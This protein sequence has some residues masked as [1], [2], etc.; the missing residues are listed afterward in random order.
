MFQ[1]FVS[2]CVFSNFWC[3]LSV[4][5]AFTIID[6]HEENCTKNTLHNEFNG[7]PRDILDK[8]LLPF[9]G[10]A[11]AEALSGTNKKYRRIIEEHMRTRTM[12]NYQEIIGKFGISLDQF[13]DDFPYSDV[14]FMRRGTEIKND[15]GSDHPIIIELRDMTDNDED[16]HMIKYLRI[17]LD[18]GQ[19]LRARLMGHKVARRGIRGLYLANIENQYSTIHRQE[20]INMLLNAYDG[21]VFAM[22]DCTKLINRRYWRWI[23]YLSL[24]FQ[25]LCIH[26]A[27]C[28]ASFK[29]G[30]FEICFFS[31]EASVMWFVYLSRYDLRV[32]FRSDYNDPV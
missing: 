3:P 32:S 22:G 19:L 25:F 6:V 12:H 7:I 28:A 1:F 18:D 29:W 26:I 16:H 9:I 14:S 30:L 31:L 5:A 11:D 4:Y 21:R 15:S 10:G 27:V 24:A 2:T 17:D 8:I 20:I 23:L 13:M